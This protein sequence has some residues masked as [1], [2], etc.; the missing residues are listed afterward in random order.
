MAKKLSKHWHELIRELKD[1]GV[2]PYCKKKYSVFGIKHHITSKHKRPAYVTQSI[3]RMGA[4][5]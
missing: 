2:C 4:V 3:R 5:K 1:D